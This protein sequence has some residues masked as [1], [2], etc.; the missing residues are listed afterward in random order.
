MDSHIREREENK[1]DWIFFYN[2]I[3]REKKIQR[4]EKQSGTTGEKENR[5]GEKLLLFVSREYNI[6]T[7]HSW[8][9]WFKAA[10]NNIDIFSI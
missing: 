8:M 9:E 10:W 4:G 2:C 7:N 1:I 5:R 3:I 6:I